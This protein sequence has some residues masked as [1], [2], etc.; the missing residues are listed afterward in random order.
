MKKI[1]ILFIILCMSS[2]VGAVIPAN[3]P[4]LVTGNV[5]DGDMNPVSGIMVTATCNGNVENTITDGDG[6]YIVEYFNNPTV[7]CDESDMVEVCSGEICE[8]GEIVDMVFWKN[9]V[10]VNLEV[11]EFG[12]IGAA[13][14]LLGAGYIAHKRRK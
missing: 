5:Y 4:T 8:T 12:A 3:N 6:M 13:F 11:P 2:V 14:A 9:I 1:F 10:V 7:L